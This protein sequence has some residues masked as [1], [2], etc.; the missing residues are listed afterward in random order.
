MGEQE[1]SQ[2]VSAL[3]VKGHVSASTQNQAL[4][5]LLFVYRHVLDQPLGGLEE[6]VRAKRPQRLPV[7]LTRQEVRA[8]LGALDGVHWL[9]A[10]LLYGAGL[11]LLECLR[12]RVKDLD[13]AKH[14]LLVRAG[15]GDKDRVTVLPVAVAEPLAAHLQG[16][17]TLHH[18][19]LGRGFG[20]VYLPDALHRKYPLADKE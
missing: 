16:V 4:C 14:Q 19:D 17:G 11:R 8:L 12:L 3:A 2:F 1:I 6:I 15:K 13:F 20:R 18:Q 10:G 9:M 5:A 7:V